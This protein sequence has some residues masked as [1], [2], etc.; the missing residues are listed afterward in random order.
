MP[1]SED[2]IDHLRNTLD[3]SVV[4]ERAQSNRSFS[5]IEAWHA[6][7][8]ANRIFGFDGWDRET[9]ETRVVQERERTI[10]KAG[11]EK[12]GWGVSY[13]CRVR[14]T[15]R[16]GADVIVR[17][18]TG[19]GHG[20]DADL[21]QAHESAIKEA[22]SDAMKRALMQFGNPFGLALYD[23]SR[24]NV[25]VPRESKAN[26]RGLYSALQAAMRQQETD[27]DLRRWWKANARDIATLPEDW[28]GELAEEGAD[29]T[30]R[31]QRAEA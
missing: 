5:Y 16:A 15:V 7:A 1:F 11:S 14:V 23:K 2:Q 9:I 4:A 27:A 21:G 6:I 29:M 26:S 13:V 18:G 25:A 19:A 3:P 24:A 10:G 28:Q 8:E 17:E 30:E 12:P 31:F 20:I 22:E